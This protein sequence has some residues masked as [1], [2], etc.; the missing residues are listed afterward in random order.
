MY[1]IDRIE[2]DYAICEADDRTM[3]DILLSDLPFEAKEGL[4]F[5]FEDGSYRIVEN[6]RKERI[7][8][9][10]GKLWK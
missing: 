10:M 6:L 9:L 2:G 3:H 4:T 5:V 8:K 1:T 7:N